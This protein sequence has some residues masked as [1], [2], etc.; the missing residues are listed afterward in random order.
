MQFIFNSS[1]PR[2]GSEL[3]QVLMHQNPDIYGSTTSPLL[4]YQFAARNNY[5]LPEVKSQDPK[6]MKKAFISMC[7]GMAEAYYSE[8]TDRQTIIDKNRGWANYF[9]WVEQWNPNPKMICM[10][11]DLRSVFASMERIYRANRHTP[12]G[13]DNPSQMQNMTFDQRISHWSSTQPIGL[14]LQRVIDCIQRKIDSKI[15]FVKYENLCNHP[16][17]TMNAIYEYLELPTFNH[18]FVGIKK[19]VYENS[20]YFG[21]FGQHDV[22]SRIQPIEN[23]PWE[24]IVAPELSTAIVNGHRWFFDYFEYEV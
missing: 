24:P 7:R 10:I 9:E 18:D 15:L 20:G 3:L 12:E 23:K 1:M 8:I 2:S 22:K 21:V 13:P 4:E 17:S 6:L 14:A 11:R 19:S 5:N 16:Q